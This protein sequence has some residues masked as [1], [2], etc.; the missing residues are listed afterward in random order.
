M[1]PECGN[2]PDKTKQSKEIEQP[3]QAKQNFKLHDWTPAK[4]NP[5]DHNKL[6]IYPYETKDQS[7]QKRDLSIIT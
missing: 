1:E 4:L 2:T 5:T 6:K 7:N 3:S